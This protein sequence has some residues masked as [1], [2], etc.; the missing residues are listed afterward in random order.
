[1]NWQGTIGSIQVTDPSSVRNVIGHSHARTISHCTWKDTYELSGNMQNWNPNELI[2]LLRHA[3]P[4]RCSLKLYDRLCCPRLI[5]PF[6]ACR[7][8]LFFWWCC[9]PLAGYTWRSFMFSFVPW[10]GTGIQ[11]FH[12]I[13]K[14]WRT[15]CQCLTG[16][17]WI[18]G[19]SKTD[20]I[21]YVNRGLRRHSICIDKHTLFNLL[22][23]KSIFVLILQTVMFRYRH[24]Y[25]SEDGAQWLNSVLKVPKRKVD[26]IQNVMPCNYLCI[27]WSWSVFYI[28][29]S[30][31]W[32]WCLNGNSNLSCTVTE[33][34]NTLTI[35]HAYFCRKK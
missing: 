32:I 7:C 20:R 1:M 16:N 17:I 19:M 33:K 11:L 27:S 12:N 8:I 34:C 5:K 24:V 29:S 26:F 31:R 22:S 35:W 2:Q 21:V 28:L 23:N 9:L 13:D 25:L 30:I 10:D 15:R 18:S 14:T 6:R 3:L 4:F